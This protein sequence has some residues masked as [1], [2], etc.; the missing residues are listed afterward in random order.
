MRV[1]AWNWILATWLLVSAFVL[2]HSP[3]SLAM[4]VA[5]AVVVAAASL[6]SGGRPGVRYVIAVVAVALAVAA[7][8]L[9][10]V[11]GIARL[12]NGLVAAILFLV[13]LVSPQHLGEE[14]ARAAHP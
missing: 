11:S 2:S 6:A 12:N 1:I 13:A 4:T 8:L 7:L 5:A 10:G 9:P 14:G 3:T